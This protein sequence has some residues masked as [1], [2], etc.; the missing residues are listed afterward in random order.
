MSRKLEGRFST[1]GPL[2]KSIQMCNCFTGSPLVSPVTLVFPFCLLFLTLDSGTCSLWFAVQ[3]W[4]SDISPNP[5]TSRP[6]VSKMEVSLLGRPKWNYRLPLSKWGSF[7]IS[8]HCI[9]VEPLLFIFRIR[10]LKSY[11]PMASSL[12]SQASAFSVSQSPFPSR[13][14]DSQGLKLDF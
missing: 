9:P 4:P 8:S 5:S 13:C 3:R 1:T 11:L 2:S 10:A 14:H 6:I 7:P 12:K